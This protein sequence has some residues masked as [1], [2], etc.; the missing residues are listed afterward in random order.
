MHPPVMHLHPL[1][2]SQNIPWRVMRV[3]HACTLTLAPVI[4][5]VTKDGDLFVIP[6]PPRPSHV[7]V[8]FIFQLSEYKLLGAHF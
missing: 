8:C 5:T 6:L 2:F 3:C 4:I 1:S 7:H